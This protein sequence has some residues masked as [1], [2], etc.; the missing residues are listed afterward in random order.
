MK[1]IKAYRSAVINLGIDIS[2]RR[3][4]NDGYVMLNDKDISTDDIVKIDGI[5]MNEQEA[6]NEIN[7]QNW[8]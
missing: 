1:Y 7:N 2:A 3:K 5:V 4:S 6:L 8:I